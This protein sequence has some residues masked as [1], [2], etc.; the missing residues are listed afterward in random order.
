MSTSTQAVPTRPWEK[1]KS[2]RRKSAL[3]LLAGALVAYAVV[4]FTGFAGPDGWAVVLFAIASVFTF[5]K[6]RKLQIKER[7][8]AKAH[9]IILAAA[10]IAFAP[11][12]SIFVSVAYKGIA[13]LRPN[14]FVSDMRTTTPD[15]FLDMGGAAH[16]IIGSLLM[17]LIATVITLPLGI[18]SGVYV[19]EVRGRFSGL[20]RFVIQSMSGVPSIVAGLFIYTTY[21]DAVGSFSALAGS[22]ALGILMLP[23]V[24]RTS[25]EVLKLVPDDLRSAGYALGAR[26]WRSTLMIVL[27]TVRSGLITAGILGVARVIGETAPLILTALSNTSFVFNPIQGPIGSLPMYVF[28]MLQI[29]TEYSIKRAWAG[30]FILLIIVFGLFSLAR[31]VAGKD[32]R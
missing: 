1:E 13:G 25:E 20:V 4:L 21:V 30:S 31:Y 18:L 32:K 8:N 17:V 11:W 28:G 19:T 7:K 22:L 10:V 15:D 3:M 29:G 2:A 23:T 26:Q 14:F 24:A 16:A 5:F 27:P 9:L 12:I 6:G